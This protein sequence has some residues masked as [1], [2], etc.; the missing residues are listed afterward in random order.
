M[1]K[2]TFFQLTLITLILLSI[3]LPLIGQTGADKNSPGK[4]N[5]DTISLSGN[6]PSTTDEMPAVYFRHDLHSRAVDGRCTAC[7]VKTSTGFDF[8]FKSISDQTPMDFFHDNCTNCHGE[9]TAA[10]ETSGPATAQ[11]RLCHVDKMQKAPVKEEII[12]DSLHYLHEDSLAIKGKDSSTPENC[13]A[14]HHSYDE[15]T[16]TLVYVSGDELPCYECH[17]SEAR[18]GIP[19]L[20]QASHESCVG[21]HQIMA[22][23][24]TATGPVNCSGC[25][26]QG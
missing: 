21:C 6:N 22:D 10:G 20:G 25:H 4:N 24:N 8:S 18:D 15:T 7:H 16:K 23:G 9:R 14:C 1:S 2:N 19:S 3:F 17:L 12:F 5:L 26:D 13:S 11:C